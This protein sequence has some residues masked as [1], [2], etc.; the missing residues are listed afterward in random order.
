VEF[1]KDTVFLAE[2][3]QVEIPGRISGFSS[4]KAAH[5]S[6]AVLY[7][8]RIFKMQIEWFLIG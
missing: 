5:Q 4:M 6:T 2:H 7:F 3:F 8:H 1:H